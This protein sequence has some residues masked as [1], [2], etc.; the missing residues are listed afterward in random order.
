MKLNMLGAYPRRVRISSR[1]ISVDGSVSNLEKKKKK[2]VFLN[3]FLPNSPTAQASTEDWGRVIK[4]IGVRIIM[5]AALRP[6]ALALRDGNTFMGTE[7]KANQR[8]VNIDGKPETRRTTHAHFYT[9]SQPTK[10]RAD[11][12][13]MK[14]RERRTSRVTWPSFS[15][16]LSSS[17]TYEDRT[18]STYRPKGEPV[19]VFPHGAHRCHR[20]AYVW[21]A[22]I[23][24]RWIAARSAAAAI[25]A[26]AHIAVH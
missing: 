14:T 21:R 16:S 26:V 5:A 15:L 19:T 10:Q 8:L 1:G 20:T 17:R 6:R 23:N 25:D 3:F 11:K 9:A 18:Y 24:G 22:R 4:V 12:K 13:R 7:T 2:T